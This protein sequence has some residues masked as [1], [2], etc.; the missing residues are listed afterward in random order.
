ML[1]FSSKFCICIPFMSE[2]WSTQ[3]VDRGNT[4]GIID[5]SKN[6]KNT[7]TPL[8]EG[9]SWTKISNIPKIVEFLQE[10]Y[11]EDLSSSYRLFYPK[12]FFEFLFEFPKHKEEYSVALLHHNKM[13]GYIL[14]REH[15]MCLRNE[16]YPVVSVNFLCLS[17][18]YRNRNM[19]PLLI[20]EI[21][22]IANLNGIF[23]AIFTSEKDYGFSI[24][25]AKYYHFP[26][27]AMRLVEAK[28]IDYEKQARDI[29]KCR[30]DTNLVD[31]PIIIKSIYDT[32]NQ[33]NILYENFD[34]EAFIQVFKGKKDVLHTVYNENQKEFASFYI[35]HTK[36]LTSGLL[37]KRAYLYYWSGSSRI[38]LDA[39]AISSKM[40]IDM[41]DILDISNNNRLIKDIGLAEGSGSLK[42]HMYN[43]KEAILP[44][45]KL[46]FILF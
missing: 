33:D 6:T 43:I 16:S 17:K 13:I 34:E 19:A 26:M 20:K 39:I 38:I 45:N 14:A 8:P 23:Q 46:N 4:K 30:P 35:V 36:C 3:P 12:E 32:I 9:F 24:L 21:T 2:F 27:N 7:P 10:Y 18:E 44:N 29:P 5:P 25:K 22:R 28:I 41:F 40:N 1:T 15:T 37:L 11:V 42:Y 31:D